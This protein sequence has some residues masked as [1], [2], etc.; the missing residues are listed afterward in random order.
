MKQYRDKNT[1][2]FTKPF[3]NLI[4]HD[5]PNFSLQCV[6]KSFDET[7]LINSAD[8]LNNL[9]LLNG[10]SKELKAEVYLDDDCILIN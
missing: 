8:N 5:F 2:M 7:K 10:R 1:G 6:E 3:Y 4:L 9:F